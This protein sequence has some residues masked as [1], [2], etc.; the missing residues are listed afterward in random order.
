MDLSV[1]EKTIAQALE[2]LQSSGGEI[3]QSYSVW[4]VASSIAYMLIGFFMCWAA[5]K[6]NPYDKDGDVKFDGAGV[7][8]RAGLFFIGL[9][10]IACNF[11]DLV[12]PKAAAAHQLIKDL[13]W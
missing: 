4:F 5:Y 11:P 12:S 8:I 9:L 13:K 6:F 1:N 3:I 2:I 7:P 10:F